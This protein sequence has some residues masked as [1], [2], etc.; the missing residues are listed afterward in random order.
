MPYSL[1]RWFFS[2]TRN[3]KLVNAAEMTIAISTVAYGVRVTTPSTIA[4]A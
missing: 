2:L 1:P 4:S 3:T